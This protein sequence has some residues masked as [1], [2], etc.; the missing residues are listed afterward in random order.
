MRMWVQLWLSMA[1]AFTSVKASQPSHSIRTREYI[2]TQLAAGHGMPVT[3][4][5]LITLIERPEAEGGYGVPQIRTVLADPEFRVYLSE[6]PWAMN[7]ITKPVPSMVGEVVAAFEKWEAPRAQERTA[8]ELQ[9]AAEAQ[10]QREA[11]ERRAQEA[12]EDLRLALEQDRL[13]FAQREAEAQRQ[14]ISEL[15]EYRAY[16]NQVAKTAAV[17]SYRS[18]THHYAGFGTMI[19]GGLYFL[20]MVSI[21]AVR[22]FSG[23]LALRSMRISLVA[24][25]AGFWIGLLVLFNQ[26]NDFSE[27]WWPALAFGA[28]PAFVIVHGVVWAMA[29][30][31]SHNERQVQP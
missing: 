28:V 14:R 24:A 22:K 11:N 20:V 30:K 26:G 27:S 3:R 5:E 4:E 15:A 21:A 19:L 6:T 8:R 31:T 1:M 18:K 2:E 29:N 12:Q 9:L 17:A 23:S 7:C 13:A 16:T 10:R 25:F